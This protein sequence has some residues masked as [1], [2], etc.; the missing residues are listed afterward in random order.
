MILNVEG[1]Y[2]PYI[3]PT[4]SSIRDLYGNCKSIIVCLLGQ[5]LHLVLISQAHVYIVTDLHVAF[6][7]KSCIYRYIHCIIVR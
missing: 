4:I 2:D 1:V 7:S 3:D 5:P 6:E